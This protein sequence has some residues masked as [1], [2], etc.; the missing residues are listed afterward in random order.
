[1]NT[2]MVMFAKGQPTTKSREMEGQMPFEEWVY[3]APPE[4]VDFVRI[5]GNRVIRVEIAKDGRPLQIFTADVVSPML[6]SAGTPELAQ[7][8]TRTIKE[9]D[10]ET[11]PNRQEAAP[12]PS[13]RNPGETLPTNN[14]AGEM[15]PVQFPKPHTDD[16][17]GA[18]PDEQSSA[19]PA[20][21][22]TTGS[23]T[24]QPASGAQPAAPAST[25]PVN[26]TPSD[27]KQQP[28]AG[29]NQLVMD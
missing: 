17:P 16:V 8:K 4:E 14:G 13:L 3:G 22:P 20:T 5:N 9:G 25:I 2:D 7:A 10:V 21:A 18:N 23:Q 24:T 28:P 12:P 15:R 6:I 26:T 1:M 29:S 11:D 27:G 19:P